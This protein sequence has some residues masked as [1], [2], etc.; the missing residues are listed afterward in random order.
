MINCSCTSGP[1]LARR[2][3]TGFTTITEVLSPAS[4]NGRKMARICGR[5][6]QVSKGLQGGMTYLSTYLLTYL[7][8]YSLT[9]LFIYW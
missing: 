5:R 1:A 6:R 3:D 7:L 8:T 4:T 2:V 9:H